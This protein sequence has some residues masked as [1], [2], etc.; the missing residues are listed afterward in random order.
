MKNKLHKALTRFPF[1]LFFTPLLFIH[2]G[3][4]ELFGFIPSM[5]VA[6]Q[7]AYLFAFTFI[8][9][10]IFVA[11]IKNDKR[12]ALATFWILIFILLFGFI[13]DSIKQLGIHAI[14]SRYSSVLP[15][16]FFT[17]I[18]IIYFSYKNKEKDCSR[19]YKFLNI[20]FT[21]LLL[22]ECITSLR[23]YQDFRQ[24]HNL[25]DPRFKVLNEYNAAIHSE[26]HEK[27]D[28]F[29]LVF[30]AMSSTKSL[31][32][33]FQKDNSF[34][35]SFLLKNGFY[36]VRNSKSNYNWTI[37]SVSTTLNME[38]LPVTNKFDIDD[39]LNFFY[40]SRSILDNSLTRIL[41]EESYEILQYQPISFNNPDFPYETVFENMQ[42]NHFFYKTL[43]GR[44]YRD[45]FWNISKTNI[46]IL[47]NYYEDLFNKRNIRKKS[48][49]EKIIHLIKSSCNDTSRPK[50]VY[51]HFMI[52]HDPYSFDSLG[53]IK[54]GK[55]NA[56]INLTE[57]QEKEF[58][59]E[60]VQYASRIIVDMVN[61][62]KTQN[63]KKTV[64]IVLGD[65]GYKYY[66]SDQ[67][68]EV[69]HNLNAIYFPDKNYSKLYDSLS[70]INIFRILLNK[71]FGSSLNMQKDSCIY[72]G[73]KKKNLR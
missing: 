31:Q 53:N 6:K 41:K 68:N 62:I 21:I 28:I 34:L 12:A 5:L 44:I 16:I 65:H 56:N 8:L 61:Y 35:D 36:V 18:A 45:L 73:E 66:K 47:T 2:H 19:P 32:N 60:Q 37:H 40:A 43:P 57:R 24:T 15:L 3:Y 48:E 54:S 70:N 55:R 25:L 7:T 59:F 63:R 72:V 49:L 42:A 27:P 9:Y 64:L 4:N 17:F 22:V 58:Y 38:Y 23:L 11:F 39:P 29:L 46:D 13:H 67:V 69:F 26:I 10:V 50:F 30:D 71:E 14:F 51:G 52:P 20:L 1:F 33:R